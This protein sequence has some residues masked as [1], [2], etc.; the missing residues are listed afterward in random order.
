M[1][2][3][4]LAIMLSVIMAV[5]LAAIPASASLLDSFSNVTKV[6][7][8]EQGESTTTAVVAEKVETPAE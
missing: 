8:A 2:K 5:A 4:V 7:S 3:K 6:A 1:S